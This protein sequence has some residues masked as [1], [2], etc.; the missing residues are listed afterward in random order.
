MKSLFTKISPV[1][2]EMGRRIK[3]KDGAHISL[4]QDGCYYFHFGDRKFMMDTTNESCTET[5]MTDAEMKY[6]CKCAAPIIKEMNEQIELGTR[7]SMEAHWNEIL[8][9][10]N[11]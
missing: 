1:V 10:R 8:F 9:G 6:L 7:A 4:F 5:W 11:K 2:L 3:E